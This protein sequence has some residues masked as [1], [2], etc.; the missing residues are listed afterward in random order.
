MEQAGRLYLRSDGAVVDELENVVA[1]P[2]K[3][4]PDAPLF[5]HPGST[6]GR[7]FFMN[8]WHFYHLAD[9]GVVMEREKHTKDMDGAVRAHVTASQTFS[10]EQWEAFVQVFVLASAEPVRLCTASSPD[11]RYVCVATADHPAGKHEWRERAA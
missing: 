7:D 9:G 3:P 4:R 10:A 5:V 11:P 1:E 2:G 6:R 8:G